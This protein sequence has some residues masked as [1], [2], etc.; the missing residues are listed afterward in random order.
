MIKAECDRCGTQQDAP[1]TSGR[2]TLGMRVETPLPVDWREVKMRDP[3]DDAV[4]GR[5]WQLCGGCVNAFLSFFENDGAVPGLLE[6]VTLEA[7]QGAMG[8]PEGRIGQLEPVETPPER[9]AEPCP[10]GQHHTADPALTGACVRCGWTWAET[11]ARAVDPAETDAAPATVDRVV[12]EAVTDP[13]QLGAAMWP[14]PRPEGGEDAGTASAMWDGEDVTPNLTA[15][16]RL[17]ASGKRCVCAGA[18][19]GT[20]DCPMHNPD[21][22]AKGTHLPCQQDQGK[23]ECPGIFRRGLFHEHMERW[24]GVPVHRDSEPCPI[25]PDILPGGRLGEHIANMHPGDWQAWEN[26]RNR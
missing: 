1:D 3:F 5:L 16:A 7:L 11:L 13:G 10:D 18:G 25:C 6:P 17:I 23:G 19:F 8:R 14:D 24:H 15:R 20:E 4:I 12:R 21:G 26:K 9:K 22:V 2:L